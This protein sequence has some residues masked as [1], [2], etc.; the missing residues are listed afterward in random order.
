MIGLDDVIDRYLQSLRSVR[1]S[2]E[3][4]VTAY[5]ADL[6]AFAQFAEEGGACA[7]EQVTLALVR[8]YL[9][10]M[11]EAD[12]APATVAR[13]LSALRS[14]YRW[15]RRQGLLNADPTRSLRSPRQRRRL[16]GA[17]RPAEVEALMAA[18][19][20]TPAGLRDR[21]ILEL[22]YGSGLRA[23]ELVALDVGDVDRAAREVRVRMG[24]GGKQ[25]IAL[26]G[27]PAADAL[28]RYLHEG[29]RHLVR[30]PGPALFLNKL[31]ARLSDR[32]VRR[33]FDRYAAAAGERL[34][35]TPHTLR[36]TFATHLLAN[37]ADLR[38]V[39]QLLGH[40]GI[41]TTQIYTHLT[42]DHLRAEHDRA[43]PLA[44]GDGAADDEG[45]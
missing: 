6:A 19:G 24:K 33:L 18:P 11:T 36:H 17:L 35:A 34:K 26:F 31:G 43:H 25:R 39:Q 30:E 8:S 40:A 3:H 45:S 21:A 16:P 37:G 13:R 42:V 15:A 32:G 9:A 44:N 5:G 7:A 23:S 4:T 22:L 27:E 38:S 2:S 29:R 14:L 10:R 20:P 12:Y 41:G 28:D 1:R